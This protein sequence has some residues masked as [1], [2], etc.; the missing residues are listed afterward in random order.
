[1][2]LLPDP[3]LPSP[4]LPSLREL[5]VFC[6]EVCEYVSSFLAV[7]SSGFLKVRCAQANLRMYAYD[8]SFVSRFES[9]AVPNFLFCYGG[10]L[11][12]LGEVR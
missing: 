7:L 3:P 1:M 2:A 9:T 12:V 8:S 11:V 6:K 5:C 4:P 10:R